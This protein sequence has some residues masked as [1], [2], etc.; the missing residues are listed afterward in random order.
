ML[1][2]WPWSLWCAVSNGAVV[3]HLDDVCALRLCVVCDFWGGEFCMFS[4]LVVFC[5]WVSAVGCFLPWS[6]EFD[7]FHV[8]S[9]FQWVLCFWVCIMC[10]LL[11]MCL[12][13]CGV[14]NSFT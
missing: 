1:F 11:E 6:P 4:V 2:L 13:V 10:L 5:V 9:A 3:V 8:C 7:L 12:C 14:W